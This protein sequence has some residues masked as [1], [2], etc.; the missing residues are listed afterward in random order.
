[1]I[2]TGV[3][4]NGLWYINHENSALTVAIEGIEEEIILLHCQLGH[5]SFE[6][7]SKLYPDVFEK[8]DKSRLVCDACELVKHTRFT[9][10]SIGLCSCE[11]L[12][13]IHSDVLGPCSV[14]SVSGVRWFITFIDCYT[15]MTWIYMLKHKSEVL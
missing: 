10:T 6:S 13:L 5:V 14:T 7:L 11:P 3:R 9:Y 12:V 15:R 8:V 1:M 4:H 2:G